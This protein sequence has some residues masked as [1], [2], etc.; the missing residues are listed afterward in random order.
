MRDADRVLRVDYEEPGEAAIQPARLDVLEQM[1]RAV[2]ADLGAERKSVAGLLG[3]IRREV[4]GLRAAPAD[5]GPV[6]DRVATI[7]RSVTAGFEQFSLALASIENEMRARIQEKPDL[8]PLASRLDLIEEAVLS[9]EAEKAVR[10]LSERIDRLE[11]TLAGERTR[12]AESGAVLR[13]EI[14]QL[15]QSVD[16]HKSEIG[17]ALAPLP[18]R[19]AE[20]RSGGEARHAEVVDVLRALGDRMA[21][22]ERLVTDTLEKVIAGQAAARDDLTEVSDAIVKLNSNQHTL[23]ASVDQARND[24]RENIAALREDVRAGTV[25]VTGT[26]EAIEPR[27]G[28]LEGRTQSIGSAVDG[29]SGTVENMHRVTIERYFRRNRFW[30]WLFGTDDWVAASWPSQSHRIAE[31]LKAVKSVQQ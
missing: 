23:A 6:V 14:G 12:A 8:A 17:N 9:R 21:A 7:E 18:E 22:V 27:L 13:G 3:D 5:V 10:E 26:I 19:F 20:I 15:A 2:T 29:L 1:M 31:E 11:T 24:A 4:A 25:S 28:F 16:A 30:Y